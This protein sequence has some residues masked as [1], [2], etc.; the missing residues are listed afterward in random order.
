MKIRLIGQAN[1]S[2]I[3]SHYYHY[4]RALQSVK[5]VNSLAELVD[6]TDHAAIHRAAQESRPDD[7]NISFVC[8]DLNGYFRGNNINWVV[9][10]STR[11]PDT[12][13]DTMQK[14]MVWLPTEWARKVAIARGINA[15]K[16]SVVPEGVD[17]E[18]F[19]PYLIPTRNYNPAVDRF[20]FLLIG[21]YEQR[22][23]IDEAID[24]FAQVYGHDT[25]VEL[26]I[27]SDF[28]R[29]PELKRQQL[30]RKIDNSGAVNIHLVWGFQTQDQLANLYRTCHVF[31]FP[32]KAEG[33]G[34]PL[35][36]AAATGLPIIT[37]FHSGQTEFLQY[38]RS[39]CVFLNYNLE[40][41]KCPEYQEFYPNLLGD[42]G[43]WAVTSVDEIARG[44]T[45][46]RH[47]YL[48]LRD[49]AI[50]NSDIIR[51]RFSWDNSVTA[52]LGTL[53]QQNLL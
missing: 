35:I 28:F 46:A 31:L 52:S 34:L 50:K 21:K 24:A 51:N 42:Y 8:A 45:R 4:S 32:T 33:W 49:A 18:S 1:D 44:I 5:G 19:H 37:T 2:G 41:I 27:K 9:F 25:S 26:V 39:S 36:E 40:S 16:I 20:R 47:N 12:L 3:G 10:E 53:K 23:S 17:T 15:E 48:N 11:I 7:I 6:F 38:I 22:K 14:H 29:E 43:K 13:F 30:L